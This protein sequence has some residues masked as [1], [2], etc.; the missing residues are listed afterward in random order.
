MRGIQALLFIT[1]TDATRWH[2][3]TRMMM[4]LILALPLGGISE[5]LAACDCGSACSQPLATVCSG[6]RLFEIVLAGSLIAGLFVRIG[7]WLAI[8]DFCV[9]ALA[10][11]AGPF[12]GRGGTV[13]GF[14]TPHG[15]WVWGAV[16]IGAITLLLDIVS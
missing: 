15:D 13:F 2:A 5:L 16:C 6:I 9:R 4:G 7:G 10:G 12:T 1:R 11:F 3:P 14:L 8:V